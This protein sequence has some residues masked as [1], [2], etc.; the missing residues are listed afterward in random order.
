MAVQKHIY[1]NLIDISILQIL[2]KKK[3]FKPHFLKCKKY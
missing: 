2:V 1:L 3:T